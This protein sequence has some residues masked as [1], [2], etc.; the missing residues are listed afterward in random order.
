MRLSVSTEVPIAPP[1]A[2]QA[3]R[4]AFTAASAPLPCPRSSRRCHGYASRAAHRPP[5]P[6]QAP[7]GRSVDRAEG[8]LPPDQISSGSQRAVGGIVLQRVR[9]DRFRL[10]RRDRFGKRPQVAHSCSAKS[11]ASGSRRRLRR[12][13]VAGA[14]HGRRPPAKVDP[15][16][17]CL[18]SE[19]RIA[20]RAPVV[21]VR[22]VKVVLE[23]E[24]RPSGLLAARNRLLC[25]DAAPPAGADD[26][27]AHSSFFPNSLSSRSRARRSWAA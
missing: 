18:R 23:D 4:R 20:V 3:A 15:G 16:R 1:D 9:R 5:V 7:E 6:P 14:V 8:P 26:G 13:A 24:P 22:M 12:P 2:R 10:Y 21:A 17:F 25:P 11:I 27:P 19:L